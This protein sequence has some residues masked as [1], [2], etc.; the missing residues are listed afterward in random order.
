MEHLIRAAFP[1]RS[2]HGLVGR[3]VR[4]AADRGVRLADLPLENFREA[5]P[6]LD[7]SVYDVGAKAVAAMQS[8]GSTGPARER[9]GPTVEGTAASGDGWGEDS[10]CHAHARRGH[11]RAAIR[12]VTH[13]HGG[14][15]ITHPCEQDTSFAM[16]LPSRVAWSM[17][18]TFVC[19]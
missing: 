6:D 14:V 9:T 13:A 1:Q 3:L 15:G 18:A 10:G 2:A 16:I 17:I 19:F 5:H 12:D 4:K 8:Y 7:A 11:V